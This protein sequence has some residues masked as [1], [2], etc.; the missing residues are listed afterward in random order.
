M[1]EKIGYLGPKGSFSEMA[2]DAVFP[3]EELTPCATIPECMDAVDQGTVNYAVVP[4]E[5]SIEGSVNL[6]VD[7]LFYEK[8][9]VIVGEVVVP[10]RQHLM[11]HPDREENWRDVDI[12]YSHPQAI[13]QSHHFLRDTLPDAELSF[14]NST[15]LAAEW[16]QNHPEENAAAIGNS[17]AA[18]AYGLIT[19]EQ[20][21]HDYE[22]NDT[23]FV[24]L[25]R[26]NVK[27][28]R[29]HAPHVRDK[30]TMTI[31]LPN[32]FSGALHQ[33]LSAF[34][35]RH[36]NMTKI[37]SRPTK[38]G[39]GNYYFIIDIDTKMD[40]VMLPGVK[41]ELEALGCK[42]KVV[43]SYP[44]YTVEETVINSGVNNIVGVNLFL[45]DTEHRWSS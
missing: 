43:G 30:T 3:N 28:T 31:T 2:S 24:I 17:L 13:A 42:V 5:N 7:Y 26:E 16:V 8:S 9:L 44:C 34:A 18:S 35:W 22:N 21:V 1:R 27:L 25:N 45:T 20:D 40:D 33:V 36:L 14:M 10:I 12:V 41:S 19:V 23:R 32:D 6:T 15:A 39:L 38:T 29:N 37:E 11:V 4:M